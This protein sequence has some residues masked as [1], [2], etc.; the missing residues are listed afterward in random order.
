[1]LPRSFLRIVWGLAMPFPF[2]VVL[3]GL[4]S[5]LMAIILL[6]LPLVGAYFPSRLHRYFKPKGSVASWFVPSDVKTTVI[7]EG[8]GLLV[9]GS[10]RFIDGIIAMW[11]Q[12]VG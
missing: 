4:P 9:S 3:G 5:E 8:V 10:E 7:L 1:V 6:G 11:V 12:P 2:I